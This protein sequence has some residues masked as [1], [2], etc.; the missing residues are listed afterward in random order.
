[1]NLH[2]VESDAESNDSDRELQI[3]FSK[4]LLKPGINVEV[5]S[6]AE[7]IND[8]DGLTQTLE[9]LKN[10]LPWIERM[11]V[12][13]A[14]LRA[15]KPML[16]QL[17]ENP[18]DLTGD[19]V[20]DDFKREMKFYRQAQTAVLEGIP[21]LHRLGIKTRRPDDYFAQ[22][23]KTDLHMKKVREKL[24]EKQLSMERSEKA[25]KLREL[26]KYGKKVQQEVLQKR[27]KEKKEMLEQVKKYRK[28]QQA[29]LDF[30]EEADG[31]KGKQPQNKGTGKS[32]VV[33][34]GKKRQHKNARF[35]FGGQKKRSKY[36][37]K[38]SARDM[39]GFSV[40]KNATAPGKLKKMKNASKNRPGKNRRQNIKNKGK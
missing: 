18:D 7:A 16:E 2:E 35:G 21:K 23:A 8:V 24:L 31:G 6:R 13:A 11:D 37:T 12:S 28:G 32:G 27:H 17:G 10:D 22:M 33:Q 9:L 1:M 5:Q 39:S 3:A 19:Q 15:P 38:E 14:P 30:L 40:R 4:G 34:P 26:R 20:E 25:K 29:K 36:N